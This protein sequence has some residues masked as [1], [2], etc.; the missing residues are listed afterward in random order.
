ML[1][2]LTPVESS[3]MVYMPAQVLEQLVLISWIA[4]VHITAV[5][6]HLRM[7]TSGAMKRIHVRVLL[8][9]GSMN[10]FAM[11]LVL[12][13]VSQPQMMPSTALDVVPVRE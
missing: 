2:Y 5:E 1:K 10:G 7:E 13:M 9:L 3:V 4:K 6:L 11:E 12:V 8:Q